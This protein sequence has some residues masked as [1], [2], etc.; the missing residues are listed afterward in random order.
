MSTGPVAS[1]AAMFIP[2]GSVIFILIVVAVAIWITRHRRRSDP[3]VRGELWV[4]EASQDI[5]ALE[6]EAMRQRIAE[7]ERQQKAS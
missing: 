7:L 5:Q 2:F 3:V 4:V 1:L 6:M